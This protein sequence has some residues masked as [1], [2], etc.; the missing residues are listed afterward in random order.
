MELTNNSKTTKAHNKEIRA[1]IGEEIAKYKNYNKVY[2]DGSKSS[3]LVG[4]AAVTP[5]RVISSKLPD[6]YS[7]LSSELY[8]I[9][10]ALDYILEDGDH[11]Y[12]IVTDSKLALSTIGNAF[13][14][15]HLLA[16]DIINMLRNSHIKG[17]DIVFGWIPAHVGISENELADRSAK[18][19]SQ[20]DERSNLPVIPEDYHAHIKRNLQE[21]DRQEWNN[22]ARCKLRSVCEYD[23]YNPATSFCRADQIVLSRCRIGHTKLTHANLITG[24]LTVMCNVCNV[25]MCINHLFL[26]PRFED[27]RVRHAVNNDM[28]IVLNDKEKCSRF[29]NFLK[30]INLY[31]EI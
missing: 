3:N 7:V 20:L 18:E 27:D 1:R 19:A 8:A 4:C 9:I 10:T 26:C 11:K 16:L 29:V 5:T 13:Y 12:L 6:K 31:K 15:G 23:L 14:S 30:A 22:N 21:L 24:N 17:K 25:S 28:K 2:T